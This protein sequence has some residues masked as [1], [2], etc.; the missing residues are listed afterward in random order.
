MTLIPVLP[1]AMQKAGAAVAAG[2]K[3]TVAA[4]T[5]PVQLASSE[6]RARRIALCR[7]CPHLRKNPIERCGKCGC[8]IAGKAS[9]QRAHCPDN[10]PR[11]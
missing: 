4:A 5:R 3:R 8:P 11:W 9:F 10:P 6:E 2:V 7:G 1:P